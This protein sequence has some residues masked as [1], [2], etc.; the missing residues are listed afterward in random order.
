MS[1][2]LVLSGGGR[3]TANVFSSPPVTGESL[4]PFPFPL[5][6]ERGQRRV[7]FGEGHVVTTPER[8]VAQAH[9]SVAAVS[10]SLGSVTEL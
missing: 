3:F 7:A 10:S 4:S 2:Q 9:P 6:S 5:S 8:A 1:R